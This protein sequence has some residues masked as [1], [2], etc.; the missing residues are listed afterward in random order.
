TVGVVECEV[1][2]RLPPPPSPWPWR[3]LA[4]RARTR[5]CVD[6]AS[7]VAHAVALE[8]GASRQRHFEE[9][10]ALFGQSGLSFGRLHEGVYGKS[11]P[12]ECLDPQHQ[13]RRY[14]QRGRRDRT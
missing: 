9:I 2:G 13:L 8:L 3:L 10:P 14:L 5:E 12:R 6:L 4:R 11:V 1:S 7:V